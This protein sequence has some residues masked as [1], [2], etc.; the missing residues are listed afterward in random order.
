MKVLTSVVLASAL[1]TTPAM[2]AD[3]ELSAQ[4]AEVVMAQTA[5]LVDDL[6]LAVERQLKQEAQELMAELE[7]SL[8]FEQEP[9]EDAEK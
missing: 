9:A 4:L 1:M 5:E 7:A 6:Q 8:A 2:A 3:D